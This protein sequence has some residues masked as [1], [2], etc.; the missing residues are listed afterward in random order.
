MKKLAELVEPVNF[1]FKLIPRST[2]LSS[3]FF[4]ISSLSPFREKKPEV[5]LG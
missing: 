4:F 5:K 2:F 1:N 3:F